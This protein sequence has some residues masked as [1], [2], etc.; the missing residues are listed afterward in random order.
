MSRHSLSNRY[1][2]QSR[3]SRNWSRRIYHSCVSVSEEFGA[4]TDL[5]SALAK[6]G[7]KLAHV[8]RNEYYGAD[9]ASLTLDEIVQ[10]AERKSIPYEGPIPAQSRQYSISLA[11]SIIPASG[12]LITALISSGVSRYGGFK[13]LERVAV[14]HS[15]GLVDKVPSTKEDIFK[16]K[17]ISLLE[18]RR[19]MRFF[20]FAAGDF[21]DKPELQGNEDSSLLEFLKSTFSLDKQ[22]SETIAYALAFCT[23]PSGSSSRAV[24]V[25]L[26]SQFTQKLHFPHLDVYVDI[27]DRPV[28][29]GLR[30]FL[31]D[32]TVVRAR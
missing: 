32:T 16:N 27:S 29:T 19:L 23:T 31:S 18:K 14:Y 10:W 28:G 13:L 9:D 30:H 15:P 24:Q 2:L 8:D 4:Y 26:Y 25:C 22:A 12:P 5:T 17:A 6:A 21:E 20:T 11:P 3:C 1:G 7:I